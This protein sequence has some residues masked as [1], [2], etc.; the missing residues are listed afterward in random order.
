MKISLKN[1]RIFKDYTTFDIRPITVLTGPNNSGKSALA[2]LFMLLKNGVERI[3]FTNGIHRIHS[4]EKAI[5]FDSEKKYFSIYIK[6]IIP[7]F[8]NVRYGFAY[9]GGECK[10]F[11]VFTGDNEILTVDRSRHFLEISFDYKKVIDIYISR[12][13]LIPIKFDKNGKDIEYSKAKNCNI[14]F[15]DYNTVDFNNYTNVDYPPYLNVIPKNMEFL[16]LEDYSYEV[17]KQKEYEELL[18]GNALFTET[19]RLILEEIP[20]SLFDIYKNDQK[21]T[22][23]LYEK[24]LE[25]QE[26][27]ISFSA[28]EETLNVD[29]QKL[30]NDNLKYV[31]FKLRE[32]LNIEFPKDKIEIKSS[33]SQKLIFKEGFINWMKGVPYESPSL[34]WYLG[35]AMRELQ[36]TIAQSEFITINRGLQFKETDNLNYKLLLDY[37]KNNKPEKGQFIKKALEKLGFPSEIVIEQV[38]LLNG[39]GIAD[40]TLETERGKQTLLDLGY[41]FSMLL[42]ILIQIELGGSPIFIEEPEANL[43]PNYQSK[44]ADIF[45]LASEMFPLQR[46][47]LETH[48]EYLVRRLQFLTA[49]GKI[50]SASS[51]IYYFNSDNNVTSEN[52]KII[53]IEILSNGTMTEEFGPGFYDEASRLRFDLLKLDD[54]TSN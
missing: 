9:I 33:V 10:L 8:V 42:P 24:I 30:F 51:I 21:I 43:H 4:F 28:D 23:Q 52:P 15:W 6:K 37:T 39:I 1:F 47:V 41:G 32:F 17:R 46:I 14:N 2:K 5:N 34:L 49:S 13:Y 19:E 11:K 36:N 29:F 45:V 50:S 7:F 35:N 16:S 44:L 26:E 3:D 20:Y 27:K 53:P 38:N 12:E 22:N 54:N 48:S 31:E 25:I 40:L 18:V